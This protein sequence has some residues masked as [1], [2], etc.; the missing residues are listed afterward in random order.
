MKNTIFFIT[1]MLAFAPLRSQA[2]MMAADGCATGDKV[3]SGLNYYDFYIDYF[4]STFGTY[5]IY[6]YQ[7]GSEGWVDLGWSIQSLQDLSY[8]YNYPANNAKNCFY[9]WCL[10]YVDTDND[11]IL[12]ADELEAVRVIDSN[13]DPEHILGRNAVDYHFD[14]FPNLEILELNHPNWR[15]LIGDKNEA[16]NLRKIEIPYESF[17]YTINVYFNDINP[18]SHLY[19]PTTGKLERVVIKNSPML[20]F[21]YDPQDG[22]AIPEFVIEGEALGNEQGN[23][24][25]LNKYIAAGL[26]VNRIVSIDNAQVITEDDGNTY[27]QFNNDAREA[28]MK[29]LIAIDGDTQYTCNSTIKIQVQNG[30]NRLKRQAIAE[31]E[32]V[33]ID[34]EHFPDVSFRQY[35]ATHVDSNEDGV[36]TYEELGS[37]RLLRTYRDSWHLWNYYD[38][39]DFEGEDMLKN[40]INFKGIE[41]L[42]NLEGVSFG[43]R[44]WG[45]DDDT[46]IFHFRNLDLSQNSNLK[47][48]YLGTD[49]EV[50]DLKLP[51]TNGLEFINP[52]MRMGF[53]Y[54]TNEPAVRLVELDDYNAYSLDEDIENGLDLNRLTVLEGGHL[55]GNKVMFDDGASY[56]DVQ[57]VAR[58]PIMGGANYPFDRYLQNYYVLYNLVN[59]RLYDSRF[60]DANKIMEQLSAITTVAGDKQV[61][62]VRYYNLIGVESAQPVKGVNIKVTTYTDGTTKSEKI[63]R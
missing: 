55:D 8:Y 10:R 44:T 32:S 37:V 12:S 9:D 38:T 61:K 57:Y 54:V 19:L 62:S 6:N 17:N 1:M 7:I 30:W 27:L 39:D 14:W 29:Y 34:Q 47:Y 31:G 52:L 48:F 63:M 3:L 41:Y 49:A 13:A 28:H 42:Y 21:N 26:D 36:L 43:H 15:Y 59:T 53:E 20:F 60:Y 2:S 33:A 45:I 5:Q 51:E 58:P 11:S 23:T 46:K 16:L 24:F 4:N 50:I 40:V 35:L 18:F 25:S 56:V 22:V